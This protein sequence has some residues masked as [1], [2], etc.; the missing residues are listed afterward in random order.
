MSAK[1]TYEQAVEKLADKYTPADQ[2]GEHP[3]YTRA[4][5][6]DDRENTQLGYWDWA[7][8]RL[9]SDVNDPY[10]DQHAAANAE[11]AALEGA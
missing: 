8:H 5:Y 11:Y 3:I 10:S 7:Y 9:E 1:I 4:D 2:W 6:E